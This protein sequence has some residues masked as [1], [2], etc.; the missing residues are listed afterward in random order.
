MR[1]NQAPLIFALFI[2]V[3]LMDA[4][5]TYG[6][7]L[8]LGVEVEMNALLVTMIHAIGPI[9]ALAGAKTLACFCGLVLYLNARHRLLAAATGAS[10]GVAVVP[11]T[12]VLLGQ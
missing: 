2:V 6:G 12:I 8:R 10:L 9:A 1:S 7:I 5:L 3:Q 4:G 11:W